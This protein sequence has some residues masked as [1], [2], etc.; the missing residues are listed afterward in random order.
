MVKLP[1]LSV[2]IPAYNEEQTIGACL[3]AVLKQGAEVTEIIVVDNN[4]TDNTSGVVKEIQKQSPSVR[5]VFE[6]TP[7]VVSA[8]NAGFASAKGEILARIDADSIVLP[9]WATAVRQFFADH[10]NA[11]AVSGPTYPYDV[12][13]GKHFEPILNLFMVQA[14]TKIAHTGELYGSNMALRATAWQVIQGE[15]CHVQDFMEDLDVSIHLS[16]H[17]LAVGFERNMC[18]TVSARRLRMSPLT[19]WRYQRMWPRSY[20]AHKMYS[21]A[22]KIWVIASI[23]LV[24]QLIT[25]VPLRAYNPRTQKFSLRYLF[26]R[27]EERMIPEI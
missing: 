18:A 10:P 27:Q 19:Y 25:W 23:G 22:A 14:N 3:R 26:S 17:H 6:P 20:S 13:W 24:L 4:S 16:R 12:P 15:V 1:T 11:H 8:R 2:I 21:A 9:G 7:G 5:I